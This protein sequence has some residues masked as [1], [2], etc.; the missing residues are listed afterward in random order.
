MRR[1]ERGGLVLVP[2]VTD[3]RNGLYRPEVAWS[4]GKSS[5]IIFGETFDNP[6]RASIC[7]DVAASAAVA[8]AVGAERLWSETARSIENC[9]R[10]VEVLM[11]SFS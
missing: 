8:S 5:D 6:L 11:A 10:L 1:I 7:A 2:R 4:K 3:M 9:K